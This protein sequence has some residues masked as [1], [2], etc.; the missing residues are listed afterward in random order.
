MRNTQQKNN[1]IWK[2]R[3]SNICSSPFSRF[4]LIIGLSYMIVYR[5]LNCEIFVK[6]L[7]CLHLCAIVTW[8]EQADTP[9]LKRVFS[10]H[11]LNANELVCVGIFISCLRQCLNLCMVKRELQNEVYRLLTSVFPDKSLGRASTCLN[12]EIRSL[13]TH[14]L[15]V[16]FVEPNSVQLYWARSSYDLV[17]SQWFYRNC[18]LGT[19]FKCS[20]IFCWEQSCGPTFKLTL[21]ERR[22]HS[23]SIAMYP[24]NETHR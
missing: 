21:W 2:L 11:I 22:N 10:S 4:V 5:R 7:I 20:E 16:R 24:S 23:Y 1:K 14:I 13:K 15:D 3:V 8:E 19:L 9:P 17:I 18:Q 12:C 6:K